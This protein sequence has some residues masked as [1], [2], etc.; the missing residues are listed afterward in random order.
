MYPSSGTKT[1]A[2]K[3]RLWTEDKQS[4][5]SAERFGGSE[6]IHPTIF[7]PKEVA[8]GIQP[9]CHSSE[10]LLNVKVCEVAA[11]AKPSY[12]EFMVCFRSSSESV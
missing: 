5:L 12:K 10:T 9:I 7:D 2:A 8:S 11:P 1:T 4:C 3:R 6:N